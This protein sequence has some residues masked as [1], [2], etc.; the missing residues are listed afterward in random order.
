MYKYTHP[1]V[2]SVTGT[3]DEETYLKMKADRVFKGYRWTKLEETAIEPTPEIKPP[4][5]VPAA[6]ESE[7]L[8]ARKALNL[9][10][11]E[12]VKA[13]EKD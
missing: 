1:Q 9:K 13:Q 2:P 3:V 12:A 8:S 5:N 11:I 6:V 7:P 10:A 4:T